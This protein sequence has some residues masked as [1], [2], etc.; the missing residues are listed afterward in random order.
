MDRFPYAFEPRFRPLL[1]LLGVRPDRDAVVL[2]D[3][4][5]LV[6][7]FGRWTVDT[8]LSNVAG[9]EVS[10]DFRWF[11]A[12]GVR[13][14]VAD[15]GLTFG[16][17]TEAGACIRF[18]EPVAGVLGQKVDLHPGLTVTVADPAAFVARLQERLAR[19]G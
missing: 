4:D 19:V 9:T 15:R 11:K 16:S 1:R 5:R 7:R 10:R 13:V 2:T 14:S 17:N 6:A 12:I 3:D 18:H 8:P